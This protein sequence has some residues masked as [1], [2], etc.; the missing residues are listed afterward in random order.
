MSP[1]SNTENSITL[2]G[3]LAGVKAVIIDGLTYNMASLGALADDITLS[4]VTLGDAVYDVDIT[5]S[6]GPDVYNLVEL[7]AYIKKDHMAK[8]NLPC[9]F[10]NR[11]HRIS[12]EIDDGEMDLSSITSSS[13]GLFSISGSTAFLSKTLNDGIYIQDERLVVVLNSVDL[14]TA[15]RAYYELTVGSNSK[16]NVIQG[17]CEV[18]ATRL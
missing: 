1:Y 16:A 3:P 6:I 18:V 14:N 12:I 8:P 17:Y 9:L 13:F 7:K 5:Q 2:H 11:D 4:G 15:G 10:A